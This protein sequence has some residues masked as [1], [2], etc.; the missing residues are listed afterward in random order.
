VKATIGICTLTDY[1]VAQ[2]Y[3]EISFYE[4][5]LSRSVR[6][7]IHKIVFPFYA[8]L[9]LFTSHVASPIFHCFTLGLYCTTLLRVGLLEV[10]AFCLGFHGFSLG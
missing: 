9:Y 7:L 10:P 8:F 5:F 4:N 3:Q 1:S 6:N 2:K